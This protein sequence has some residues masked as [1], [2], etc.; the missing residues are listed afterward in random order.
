M[1]LGENPKMPYPQGE[2]S[3]KNLL[4]NNNDVLKYPKQGF[5]VRPDTQI[6][7]LHLSPPPLTACLS[8]G[9][10][11]PAHLQ[12]TC[13]HPHVRMCTVCLPVLIGVDCNNRGPVNWCV[14]TAKRR[15]RGSLRTPTGP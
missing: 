15:A 6:V 1:K 9:N 7:A 12:S 3:I 5:A 8:F 2:R 11:M 13:C 4:S 10:S 14:A